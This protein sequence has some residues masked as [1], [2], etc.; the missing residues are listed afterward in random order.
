MTGVATLRPLTRPRRL[1]PGDRVAVVA[2]SGPLRPERLA[3]GVA[4]LESW[5][6]QVAV[7]RHAL[8]TRR[9][10]A[11]TDQQR[12]EDFQRAWCDPDVRAV[13]PGRGG[14]GAARIVDLLDWTAMAAAGPKV[15]VGFSD[16]TV[17]HAAVANRLGLASLMGPMAAT[18]AFAGDE[19]DATTVDGLRAALFDPQAA[20]VLADGALRAEVP[21]HARG[22]LVG[23]TLAVLAQSVGTPEHRPA[24]GGLVVLEDVAEPTYRVDALLTQLLRAGW[25]DGAAGV[26]LGTWHGCGADALEVVV[27]RLR[28][29]GVPVA[30]GLPFGHGVPQ[31]TVP[32]GVEAE[33]D[34]GAG[35]LTVSQ[36]ALR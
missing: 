28:P 6:L 23:G 18:E 15:L 17:L 2:T 20:R 21:G 14:S 13:I 26:V 9:H 5:G 7:G 35:R 3:R 32:L 25:F 36:P 27:E 29:L 19:P 33:L 31:L 30:S 8:A 24:R 12:A 34:V 10:L 22:V 16:V 1:A 11:G 4:T